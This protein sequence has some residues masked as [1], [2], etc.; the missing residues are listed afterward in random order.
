MPIVT[1]SADFVR[2]AVCPEGKKKIDYYSNSILGF[3]L[4]VRCTGR[5]TYALR[6]KNHHGRQCQYKIGD[7]GSISFD[8]AKNA[9]QRIRSRVVLGE[10]PSDERKTKQI[11]PTLA[12]F[13]AERYMP[14]VKGYKKS[15]ESDDASLRNHILPKFGSCRLDEVRSA[16]VIEFHHS[17]KAN[18]YAM[19]TA[20]RMV[21]LLRYMYNLARKWAIPGAEANPTAGVQLFEVNNAREKFLTAEETQC[22]YDAVKKSPNPQLQYIVAL[23]LLLGNRKRELLDAQ[24]TD[25]DLERRTW[26][27]PLAKSGKS[28]HVPLSNAALSV[29]SQ[30]PRFAGCPYVVPN[31]KTLQP[32]VSIYTSWN[33]ARNAAG[34]PD[35]RM[36]DLRHSMASNMV[37]SGRSLYEVAKV[38]GHSQLKTTQRY[39]HLSQ[40]TLL[41][42]VDAAADA[43]GTNW[44]KK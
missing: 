8:K 35:V 18:G 17:K 19:A 9:A 6:Y 21:V 10:D 16:D 37:N 32:F 41:A 33:T 30:L 34:L 1:L 4:E 14:Y 22:L 39:S 2:N 23:L 29:L 26:R 31:P 42:A 5:K 40:E 3:I 20:N 7:S 13:A 27:I 44:D 43:T 28:R 15:W 25:F 11:I 12:E 38:L 36:H 24:W